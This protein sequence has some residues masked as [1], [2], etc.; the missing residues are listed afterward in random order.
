MSVRLARSE[1]ANALYPFLGGYGPSEG[2]ART[3]L[4][5]GLNWVIELR[6]EGD[7]LAS[8]HKRH[9]NHRKLCATHR[10]LG[11]VHVYCNRAQWRPKRERERERERESWE[12]VRQ[13]EFAQVD[14]ISRCQE[15][16]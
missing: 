1:L 12:S 16:R 2:P 9:I 10:I 5:L 4:L 15:S 14:G 7:V 6:D 11:P 8:R 3:G 13:P